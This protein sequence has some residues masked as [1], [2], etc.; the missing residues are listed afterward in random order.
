MLAEHG[1]TVAAA[2]GGCPITVAE[3]DAAVPRGA[4]LELPP[5]GPDTAI[6]LF[7]SSAASQ[8]FVV[9]S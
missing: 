6:F 7:F 3:G 9:P 1:C 5:E 2:V 8:A 4:A